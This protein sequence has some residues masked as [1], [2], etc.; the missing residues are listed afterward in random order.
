MH[1]L[2]AGYIQLERQD[3]LE[4]MVRAFL[5]YLKSTQCLTDTDKTLQSRIACSS[6]I[7]EDCY[8]F[9]HLNKAAKFFSD[10]LMMDMVGIAIPLVP[11]TK[12][13]AS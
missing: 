12:I 8:R 1:G 6:P 7:W 2:V 9:E 4:A 11:E 5:A 3:C 10:A 13:H